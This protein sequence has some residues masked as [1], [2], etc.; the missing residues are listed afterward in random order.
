MGGSCVCGLCSVSGSHCL[1]ESNLS[2]GLFSDSVSS[3]LIG[4]Y[5]IGERFICVNF[6]LSNCIGSCFSCRGGVL[7]GFS[8]IGSL[9]SGIIEST[10]SVSSSFVD[11]SLCNSLNRLR[12]AE[13]WINNLGGSVS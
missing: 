10:L 5:L 2:F 3:C 1:V 13:N 9:L 7:L 4:E 6:S 12:F 8:S 11:V